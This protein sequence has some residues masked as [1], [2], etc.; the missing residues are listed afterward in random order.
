M[1]LVCALTA[2]A[3]PAARFD[4]A[5]TSLAFTRET[6][7][8]KG[9]SHAVFLKPGQPR[10]TLHIYLDGDGSPWL[11]GRWIA[12]D[13]TPTDP[14]TLQLMKVDPSPAV[15]IGRPCY[16]GLISAACTKAL[17]TNA[18]YSETVVASMTSAIAHLRARYDAS[19]LVLIGYS[20]GGTLAMLI[21]DRLPTVRAVVTLAANLDVDSWTELHGYL[22]LPGSMNPALAAPLHP[23]IVQLHYAGE[24]DKNVPP[25][26]VSTAVAKQ[27]NSSVTVIP[28]FDH[29]CCWLEIWPDILDRLH[30]MRVSHSAASPL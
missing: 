25:G 19:D 12:H 28:G 27:A 15:Y 10:H 1:L 24:L 16:H 3:T 17:W 14:L 30:H 29:R 6:V 20:G 18:R 26:L 11:D 5:A 21:A 22:P 13:P 8:G 9:F 2:C 23:D 7:P 4:A